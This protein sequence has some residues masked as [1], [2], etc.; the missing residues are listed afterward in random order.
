[1]KTSNCYLS[2]YKKQVSI[3]LGTYNRLS[4]LKLTIDSIRLEMTLCPFAYEIIVID[5]GSTDGTLKWLAKQKDILSIIQH[6]RGECCG[7]PI[8]RRSWGYF[9]NLG[10]KCAQGKYVCMLS[11]DSLVVPGAIVNGIALFEDRLTVGDNVGAVAFYWRNWPEDQM[12]KVGLTLSG[13]MT[14]NHGLYLNDALKK[15]GFIDEE[16]FNFYYADGDLCLKIWHSGY[17]VVE[18]KNSYIEHYSHANKSVRSTNF[19][20]EKQDWANYISKWD[21]VYY[22][23]LDKNI[24]KSLFSTYFDESNTAKKFR[25]ADFFN[26][27]II[28][29]LVKLTKYC[30]KQNN[31]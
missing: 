9:M 28:P 23:Q 19:E 21:G 15:V 26:Y 1:M 22:S 25:S 8:K 30:L 11:D 2:S 3:V 27:Y 5:G 10:F 6:N 20:K 13:K 31:I 16:N 29:K 24:G 18:S 17:I 4:F 12:Y 7:K 14:V